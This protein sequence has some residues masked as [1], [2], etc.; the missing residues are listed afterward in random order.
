M[1]HRRVVA[2]LVSFVIALPV[3]A[4]LNRE[5]VGP[6]HEHAEIH[7]GRVVIETTASGDV[8]IAID[9]AGGGRPRGGGDGIAE[10]LFVLQRESLLPIEE[11]YS[12]AQVV[13]RRNALEV[14][15]PSPAAGYVFT[16]SGVEL[17]TAPGV[18]RVEGYGL[19]RSRGRYPLAASVDRG[20]TPLSRVTARFEQEHKDG[21]GSGGSG[22]DCQAGGPGSTSCSVTCPSSGSDCS[23]SCLAGYHACC[24]CSA[25]TAYCSCRAN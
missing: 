1:A 17:D 22:G 7:E 12:R 16:L 2:V 19:S 21:S 20:A 25:L 8:F 6:A 23:T 11:D 4:E 13:F 3:I 5:P 14:R 15:P 24:R 9:A 10:S 18:E